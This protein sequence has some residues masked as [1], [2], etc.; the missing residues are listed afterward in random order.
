[1]R[2]IANGISIQVYL[3]HISAPT[4]LPFHTDHSSLAR[5]EFNDLSGEQHNKTFQ[6][7]HSILTLLDFQPPYHPINEAFWLIFLDAASTIRRQLGSLDKSQ[8]AEGTH[9]KALDVLWVALTSPDKDG[10]EFLSRMMRKFA[11]PT[12]EETRELSARTMDT[13][14]P[15]DDL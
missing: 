10:L 6:E 11:L 5:Q 13:V 8:D 7:V 15:E 9:N 2:G 14:G 12:L 4:I 1:M 3:P